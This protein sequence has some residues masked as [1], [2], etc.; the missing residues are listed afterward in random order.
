MSSTMCHLNCIR[1][2]M[3]KP[4]LMANDCVGALNGS[5]VH[6]F[7]PLKIQGKF[8][9]K[10]KGTTQNVLSIIRLKLKFTF[11]LASWEGNAHD[12]CILSDALSRLNNEL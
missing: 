1:V 12:F 8:H 6:A 10:K 4:N 3:P 11:V 2:V 7:V 5:L 9:G